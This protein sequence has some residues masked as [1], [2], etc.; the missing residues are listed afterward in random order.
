M[1]REAYSEQGMR[2]REV[3]EVVEFGRK[4][5]NLGLQECRAG[6]VWADHGPQRLAAMRLTVYRS[7]MKDLVMLRCRVVSR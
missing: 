7:V 1:D 3:G 4:L 2:V 6:T 5:I